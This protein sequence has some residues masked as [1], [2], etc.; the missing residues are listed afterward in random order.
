M[1]EKERFEYYEY[2]DRGFKYDTETG[3]IYR[4]Q[5]GETED[6]IIEKEVEW[7]GYGSK[8]VWQGW[9]CSKQDAEDMARSVKSYM[10]RQKKID[11]LMTQDW[12]DVWGDEKT[13][14]DEIGWHPKCP[15]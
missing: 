10:E 14:R 3:K 7:H 9:K 2:D 6:V 4:I 15:D 11:A 13:A 1:A 12:I 8:V 5:C